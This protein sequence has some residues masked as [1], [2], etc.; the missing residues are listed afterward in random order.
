[1]PEK[2]LAEINQEERKA[3]LQDIKNGKPIDSNKA[4][5]C[6]FLRS[7]LDEAKITKLEERIEAL[8]YAVKKLEC[9]EVATKVQIKNLPINKKVKRGAT[10]TRQQTQEVIDSLFDEL[11]VNV[12]TVKDVRRIPMTIVA[13]NNPRVTSPIVSLDFYSYNA[14]MVFISSLKKLKDS[15][16]YSKI[17]VEAE[18]PNCLVEDYRSACKKAMELRKRNFKT[19]V[20]I[21]KYNIALFAKAP[22]D[23]VFNQIAKEIW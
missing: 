14:K 19:K 5:L 13:K 8:E 12:N 17:H 22:N 10:E 4:L 2:S 7:E 23:S 18:I 6:L 1:M 21:L 20:K 16:D 15:T 9:N 11:D 3:L